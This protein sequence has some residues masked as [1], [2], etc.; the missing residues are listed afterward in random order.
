MAVHCRI[1]TEAPFLIPVDCQPATV[2]LVVPQ[3][4][5]FSKIQPLSS[6]RYPFVAWI[7]QER[8]SWSEHIKKNGPIEVESTYTSGRVTNTTW[9]QVSYDANSGDFSIAHKNSSGGYD[10]PLKIILGWIK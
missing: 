3:E 4:G 5:A 7:E 8:T 2:G 9:T 6:E 1:L 10:D